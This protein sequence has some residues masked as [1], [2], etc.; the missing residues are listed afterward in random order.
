MGLPG[1]EA[2]DVTA[3]KATLLENLT[4]DKALSS[5][6]HTFLLCA[7]LSSQQ[8]GCAQTVGNKLSGKTVCAHVVSFGSSIRVEDAVTWL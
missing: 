3:K 2:T 5:D 1:N 7:V 8:D 4:S 6:I